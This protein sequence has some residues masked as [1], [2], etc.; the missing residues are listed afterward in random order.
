MMQWQKKYVNGG[1]S[2]LRWYQTCRRQ[3]TNETRRKDWKIYADVTIYVKC[4]AWLVLTVCHQRL[5]SSVVISLTFSNFSYRYS[6]WWLK[7]MQLAH[8]HPTMCYIHLV[9][10][11]VPLQFL[12]HWQSIY[13][14]PLRCVKAVRMLKSWEGMCAL[15]ST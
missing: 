9:I 12:V 4:Q 10:N 11:K 14:Y 8:A 5:P 15:I 6:L 13:P 7:C 3:A 2:T 1:Q